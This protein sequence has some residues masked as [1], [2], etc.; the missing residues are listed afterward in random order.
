MCEYLR[1]NT[2]TITAPGQAV[3][4]SWKTQN[5]TSISINN[6]VGSVSPV[7]QGSVV[8][9]PTGTTT[10]VAT[11]TGAS[12][13]VN[14]Q[15][16]VTLVTTPPPA[17][18]QCV[19]LT[20]T[21]TLIERGEAV[22]LRWKT[23]NATS[24]SIN[25]GVGSVTPVAEGSKVVYPTQSTT[26]VATVT[27]AQGSVNCQTTVTVRNTPP[28]ED[29]ARCVYLKISDSSIE[30]GDR[31]T[32]SWKTE[33]ASS[34]SIN[35]GIGSVRPVSEGSI[36]VRPDRD[37]TYV[38]T[39]RGGGQS[40]D[41]SVTVRVD[42][43]RERDRDRDRPDVVIDSESDYDEPTSY[44]YLSEVPYTGL[45]LGTWGTVLY[46]LMLIGWSGALAYLVLFNAVPF[47]LARVKGFGEDVK[48]ALN[49]DASN[50]SHGHDSHA[51]AGHDSHASHSAHAAP[52]AVARPTGYN[53][54]DGFRSF[55]AGEGLT[56]DDIVK[57]LS[58]QIEDNHAVEVPVAAPTHA[59]VLQAVRHEAP[60]YEA[61]Q[62]AAPVPVSQDVSDFIR[63][64][65][66]GDRDTVFGTVRTLARNGEDTELFVSHA[67]CALDDAYRASVEGTTCHPDIKALTKDCHPSFL[68]RLVTSLSTAVD[69][70]Y[71][72]GMTGVK[73]A[74]T[75][76]LG[77]VA[78]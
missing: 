54:H 4:L 29:G 51:P 62:V 73:M 55:A 25:N 40:D 26:Y 19:F 8:V 76:A 21:P 75:R 44:V 48:T 69:G 70:S 15:T 7:A 72:A 14:C 20:G 65:L 12:G 18:A 38:A 67:A 68:E 3:T 58:R 27:N 64:L 60:V 53:S 46:W 59:E 9:R 13:S 43:E 6:G 1:A 39:V 41:C 74:L 2:T 28:V 5:A 33:D 23:Q 11:V 45:E 42:D 52:A 57:G 63:A 17:S 49:S 16:K 24:I 78:G 50:G 56:I 34:I 22:T 32:L 71:S 31:V 30:E 61:P 35:Q 77:V 47:A 37:T 66:A 36:T 10:Y